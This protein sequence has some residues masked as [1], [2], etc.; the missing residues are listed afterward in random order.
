MQ[1]GDEPRHGEE[2]RGGARAAALTLLG[3]RRLLAHGPLRRGLPT[4]PAGGLRPWRAGGRL[5]AGRA[6]GGSGARR[7]A[8]LRPPRAPPPAPPPR[9]RPRPPPP[10]PLPLH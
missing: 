8:R 1:R 9:R 5:D 3:W 6:R 4:G 10:P 7:P 2:K